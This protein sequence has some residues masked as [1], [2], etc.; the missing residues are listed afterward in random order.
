M[1]PG[2][3]AP[4]AIARVRIQNAMRSFVLPVM[5]FCS[6]FAYTRRDFPRDR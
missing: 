4:P 2:R 1:S 3:S 5:F 6:Y